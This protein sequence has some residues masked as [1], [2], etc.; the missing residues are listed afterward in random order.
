M[1]K[2]LMEEDEKEVEK[3]LPEWILK[4]KSELEENKK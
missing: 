1:H 3:F 4:I 2:L